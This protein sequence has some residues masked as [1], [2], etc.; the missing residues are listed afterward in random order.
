MHA[1]CISEHVE[2]AGAGT[3]A[4]P[5]CEAALAYSCSCPARSSRYLAGDM[6]PDHWSQLCPDCGDD[7]WDDGDEELQEFLEDIYKRFLSKQE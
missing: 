5:V 7:A 3:P 1:Q 4:C 2:A 6:A